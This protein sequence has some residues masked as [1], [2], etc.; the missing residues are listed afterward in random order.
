MP[1]PDFSPGEVLTAAAM[2]SIGMWKVGEFTANGTS[3]ALVC[4]N[5][6]TNDYQNYKIVIKLGT[7]SNSNTL[8]YQYIN[9][10]GATVA[11]NYFSAMY[12]KDITVGTGAVTTNNSTTVAF[13]GWIPNGLGTP[14]GAEITIYGPRLSE[15]TSHTGQYSGINSGTQFQSGELYGICN[16]SPTNTMR[17]LRFDNGAGTNLTGSVRVYGYRN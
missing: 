14:L 1:V 6:F 4:D 9:T 15:W 5:I 13:M 7:T 8:Y 16:P 2:D 11:T 10:S 3:R 17:G 12:S